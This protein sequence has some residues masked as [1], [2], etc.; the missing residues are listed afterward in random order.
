MPTMDDWEV[1]PRE[2]AAVAM[3]AIEQGIAL[4]TDL[5]YDQEIAEATAMI[6]R[7]RGLVQ[8][9]MALGYIAMPEGSRAPAPTTQALKAVV[10]SAGDAA[11]EYAGKAAEAARQAADKAGP[12][13]EKAAD[14]ARQA[15]DKAGPYAEKAAELARDAAD[16]AAEALKK[17]TDRKK[18]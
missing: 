6:S 12:Y 5:T 16:K 15:A 8:D 7:A 4:R 11:A 18:D 2:A 13:A 1:F 10:R 14:A 17:A 3:K 9:A